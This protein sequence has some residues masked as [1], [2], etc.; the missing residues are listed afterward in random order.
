MQ[1]TDRIDQAIATNP[2][3]NIGIPPI[4]IDLRRILI[5]LRYHL[6]RRKIVF[7]SNR[8]DDV[9][10]PTLMTRIKIFP[11]N[12]FLIVCHAKRVKVPIVMD[13]DLLDIRVVNLIAA[14]LEARNLNVKHEPFSKLERNDRF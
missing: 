11:H 12:N 14:W 1:E 4:G 2:I 13:G 5:A 7:G 3:V 8:N 6:P 9:F 10:V